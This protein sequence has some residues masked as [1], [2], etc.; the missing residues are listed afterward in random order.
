MKRSS[1]LL[2]SL[3]FLFLGSLTCFSQCPSS[4]PTIDQIQGVKSATSEVVSPCAGQTVTTSGIVTAITSTGFFIEEPGTPPAGLTTGI[5]INTAAASPVQVADNVTVTGTVSTVPASNH[6]SGT[7]ITVNPATGITVNSAGQPLPTP[8]ALDA[9]KL[10]STGSIYQ[11]TPYEAMRVSF[12]SLTAVSG[13]GGTLNEAAETYNS[14]GQFYAVITATSGTTARPFRATGIDLRDAPVPNAPASVP[15][16]NDNPQRILVDSGTLNGSTPLDVATGTVITGASGVVGVLDFTDSLDANY[17]P[18]RL[19]LDPANGLNVNASAAMTVQPVAAPA[20][21]QFTIASLNLDRFYNT[22]SSDDIYYVPP[23]VIVNG[24]ASTGQTFPSSAVDV[25]S[26]AYTNRLQKTALAICNVLNTPDIIALEGIENQNVAADIAAAINTQCAVAYSAYGTDNTN[27]YTLDSTGISIG[28]LLKNSTVDNLGLAQGGG[29]Q[30]YLPTPSGCE[31]FTPTTG[32]ATPLTLNLRPWLILTAGIKRANAKDY[33]VVVI[34]NDLA[35]IAGENSTTSTAVR[36]QKEMQAEEIS[37]YI[38]TLQAKGIHVISIGNFSAFEFSDGYTDTL[39]TYTNNNVLP[40]TEVVQP[41]K[42]G[43][44]TPSLNDL[45]LTIPASQRWSYVDSGNAEVLDHFVI[46]SELASTTQFAYAH[47]NADFPADDLQNATLPTRVTSHDA[48]IGYFNIPAPVAAAFLSPPSASFGNVNVGTSSAGQ[49]FTLSNVGETPLTVTSITASGDFAESN[50]CGTS[51]ALS[52][53]CT[54]NVVF[55]PTASG[56]RTGTLSVV[57]SASA[58]AATATLTGTGTTP[59]FTLADVSGDTST[60]VTVVAGAITTATL[61]FTPI[62]GFSGTIATTCT[63]QGTAPTGVTC[64]PPASFALSGTA[65]VNQSVSFATTARTASGGLAS[66]S[67]N[68]SPWSTAIL[69]ALSGLLMF[70]AG[71]TRRLARIS[72]LLILLLAIFI[73]AIGCSGGGSSNG[74]GGGTTGT[75]AGSYTYTVTATSG[76]IS[77]SE[78]VTLVVQ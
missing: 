43:L 10:S 26:A 39:A 22:S 75:P 7:E 19:L 62:N 71:R 23:G 44:V 3:G 41:G 47:F 15:V 33:A 42:S 37:A 74:G 21:G 25:T 17:T 57:T 48:A 50:N 32:S 1:P 11:L 65:A 58:N 38:Q 46:T 56:A 24:T 69:L 72:G 64:T 5:Y 4:T 35:D 18:A 16:F 67:F 68:R 40:S 14:N 76:S 60:T 55:T 8:V 59:D 63:A 54:I 29:C 6:L 49:Q 61:V 30:T 27:F 77:H 31:T 20:S 28:F 51:L 70:L 36:Q 2:L 73:P 66:G 53:S 13:T 52:A 45:T 9:T 12:A 34:N 78:T